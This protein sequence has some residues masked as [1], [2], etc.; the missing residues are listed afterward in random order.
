MDDSGSWDDDED[1]NSD[2]PEGDNDDNDSDDTIDPAV[3]ASDE[4][5]V[6]VLV[7]EMR[8][9]E[10][11][12]DKGEEAQE[13]TSEEVNLGRACLSKVSQPLLYLLVLNNRILAHEPG[14]M[15]LQ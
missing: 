4:M 13:L 7:N 11:Q 8:D 15:N 2:I 9:R 5:T 1:C 14:Q 3:E 10:V 6:K 12:G